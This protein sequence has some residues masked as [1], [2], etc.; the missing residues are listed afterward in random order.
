MRNALDQMSGR[1]CGVETGEDPSSVVSVFLPWSTT[2]RSLFLSFHIMR[3][4]LEQD[5]K[6][7]RRLSSVTAYLSLRLYLSGED[8]GGS[9]SSHLKPSPNTPIRVF[10]FLFSSR[11]WSCAL[12]RSVPFHQ[13]LGAS[14]IT[15]FQICVHKPL[16]QIPSSFSFCLHNTGSTTNTSTSI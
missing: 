14:L 16:S 8:K 4:L 6:A 11:R 5:I 7:V 15:F 2:A 12:A 10:P 1:W 9:A 13:A 3:W